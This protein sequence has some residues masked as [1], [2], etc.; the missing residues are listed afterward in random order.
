MPAQSENIWQRL[1]KPGVDLLTLAVSLM[2]LIS[3]WIAISELR[4]NEQTTSIGAYQAIEELSLESDKLL[5]EYPALFQYFKLGKQLEITAPEYNQVIALA[6]ARI[7]IVDAALTYAA[8][9]HIEN[10]IED[11][12]RKF[13][14]D[15]KISRVMCDRLAST[16]DE[17]SILVVDLGEAACR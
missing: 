3:I 1:I 7:G 4:A 2:G 11:W 14:H 12:K 15:F 16:R 9:G 5:V 17:Y 8:V 6:D 13:A 10:S